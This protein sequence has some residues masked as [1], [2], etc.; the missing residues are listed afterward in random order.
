[1]AF[2]VD[3]CGFWRNGLDAPAPPNPSNG[4]FLPVRRAASTRRISIAMYGVLYTVASD[5]RI[6][7]LRAP[8]GFSVRRK[9]IRTENPVTVN[10]QS[11]SGFIRD[12]RLST[13]GFS[14]VLNRQSARTAVRATLR[15]RPA[16]LKSS[17]LS[18]PALRILGRLGCR[19]GEGRKGR[20][21]SLRCAVE[22][23][24]RMLVTELIS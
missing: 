16:R 3:V 11:A 4:A 9:S 12:C 18:A 13:D 21:D 10:I 22:S 6:C 8:I 14:S 20:V 1:M 5:K 23:C 24:L 15:Q 2:L 19:E 17:C 7:A